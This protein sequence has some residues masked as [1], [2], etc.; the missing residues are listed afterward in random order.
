MANSSGGTN[1]NSAVVVIGKGQDL[2]Q[3]LDSKS[4]AIVGCY[5]GWS[6][7]SEEVITTVTSQLTQAHKDDV[8]RTHPSHSLL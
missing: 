5:A 4:R 3:V 7:G 2:K 1:R 8:V 6:R